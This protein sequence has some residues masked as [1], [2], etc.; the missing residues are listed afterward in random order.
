MLGEDIDAV[1]ESFFGPLDDALHNAGSNPPT[2]LLGEGNN[3]ELEETR[4]WYNHQLVSAID[5]QDDAM[6]EEFAADAG[7]GIL[8][9]GTNGALE[10]TQLLNHE[11]PV[12]MIGF[13][14]DGIP[15]EIAAGT[16]TGVLGEGGVAIVYETW[17]PQLNTKRAVKLWRTNL[18]AQIMQRFATETKIAG[19]LDHPN[20]VKVHSFGEWH[21]RPYIEMDYVDGWTL[22]S[23]LGRYHSLPTE[24]SLAIAIMV[25][26]A[27]VYA[28]GISDGSRGGLGKG[29]VHCDIK[30][31]NILVSRNG[32]VKLA[33]FGCALPIESVGTASKTVLGSPRYCAPE[34]FAGERPVP[35]GDVFSLAAVLYEMLSGMKLFDDADLP[36]LLKHRSIY[37]VTP[38]VCRLPKV[39]RS[40]RG[41]V[42]RGLVFSPETRIECAK[43][44]SALKKNYAGLTD[45]DPEEVV[46]AFLDNE[47]TW[48]VRKPRKW[49]PVGIA[50]A[51][52][53]CSVAVILALSHASSN[54]SQVIPAATPK[55]IITAQSPLEVP[56]PEVKEPLALS[57]E[58]SPVSLPIPEDA[59]PSP[60]T[61]V[62]PRVRASQS[63]SL[64]PV[65]SSVTVPVVTSP[66]VE[67]QA[68]FS[69]P[70][71]PM[72]ADPNETILKTLQEI[73]AKYAQG[74]RGALG[75]I[76]GEDPI[77]DGEYFLWM[78]RYLLDSGK[79][80]QA[81]S[82]A[83][84]A[85]TTP[86]LALSE[87]QLRKDFFYVRGK[88]L[89]FAYNAEPGTTRGTTAMEAWYDVKYQLK[90]SPNDP[91]FVAADAELRRISKEARKEQQ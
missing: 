43:F 14:D 55:A 33:D 81:L 22:A 60:K 46:G 50:A 90:A 86:S 4:E 47:E 58:P 83:K 59:P 11:Q 31:A 19:C 5:F 79:W 6:P 21:G 66:I 35:A 9:E 53:F 56:I 30:P 72:P 70:K 84:K 29:I 37:H 49:W 16:V 77:Q 67:S 69:V 39:R 82:V 44:L 52:T 45:K 73:R 75:T 87:D 91:R 76:F 32:T 65:V 42:E 2:S 8:D 61:R 48:T 10:Q 7:S 28:H 85:L 23:L 40:L 63:T 51:L 27:L 26:R 71:I 57:Q 62:A 54:A 12:Q 24:L 15:Q 74:D 80:Q 13:Q 88:C 64:D 34:Q 3:R 38:P 1:F 25:C 68:E 78:A 36:A 20:I 17:N 41:L 18:P 89:S